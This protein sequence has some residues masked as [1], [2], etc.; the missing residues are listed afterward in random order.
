MPQARMEYEM[1]R[2]KKTVEAKEEP[3]EKRL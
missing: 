2:P 1:A 3:I